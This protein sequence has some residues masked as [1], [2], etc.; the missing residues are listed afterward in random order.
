MIAPAQSLAFSVQ[1]A[2][3]V[4]ALLLGSGVSRAAG[5]PT[6]WEITLDLIRKLASVS[7]ET[8][9]PSPETWYRD[10][11]GADPDYSEII[12]P[13]AR[14]KAERQQLLRSYVEPTEQE[15]EDG[16]KV[17]TRAHHA[18]AGLVERK[19]VRVIVTTNFDRLIETALAERG[20]A[21]A[22]LSSKHQIRGA[23]PLTHAGCT[24]VKVHGDYLDT[25]LRNTDAELESYPKAVDRFLDRIFREFGLVV[26]GWSAKWDGG[27]RDALDRSRSRRFTTYWA[28]RSDL[29]DA[30]RRLVERRS[31]E[32]IRIEDADTFFSTLRGQVEAIEEFSQP[33]PLSAEV[34]VASLK[35]YLPERR[36][37]VRFSDLVDRTVDGVLDST[38]EDG[39]PPKGERPTTQLVTERVQR[40]DAAC[41]TLVAIA[42]VGGRW[43]KRRHYAVWCRA[44]QRL[45][46]ESQRGGFEVWRDL[47][48]YPAALLLYALGISAAH[49]GR[50]R[51][52]KCLLDTPVSEARGRDSVAARR[53]GLWDVALGMRR[54]DVELDGM[55]RKYLPLTTWVS[56]LLE[57][58]ALRVVP[59]SATYGVVFDRF[60]MLLALHCAHRATADPPMSNV[61]RGSFGFRGESYKRLFREFAESLDG[62]G[63]ESPFVTSGIFGG[64]AQECEAALRLLD[65]ERQSWRYN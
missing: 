1:S 29:N 37:R 51:F 65:H 28:T 46:S 43:A 42:V 34:A 62:L 14:T 49:S 55:E 52:L 56:G 35:R 32:V 57:L 10:T 63:S 41:S 23:L 48:R 60:E 11:F 26:C 58:P 64:T 54:A 9:G 59:D 36:H 22:V 25:R 13:L 38:R 44:L 24:V 18:I 27:L 12:Q 3:G 20:I 50:L 4:Y 30:S 33:H 39:F 17:P 47:S 15:R 31:A 2:P 8:A 7:G 16:K 53:L 21:P 5:I 6:G 40:Y 61:P 45:V 19:F